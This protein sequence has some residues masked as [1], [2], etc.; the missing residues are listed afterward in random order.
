MWGD[1]SFIIIFSPNLKPNAWSSAARFPGG[2][3]KAEVHALPFDQVLSLGRS[4]IDWPR[5]CMGS[6]S[7]HQS[8]LCSWDPPNCWMSLDLSFPSPLIPSVSILPFSSTSFQLSAFC[9][10]IPWVVCNPFLEK[11]S[12]LPQLGKPLLWVTWSFSSTQTAPSRPV[13]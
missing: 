5:A 7:L 12:K 10:I 11:Q 4:P 6:I 13:F 1:S 3:A 2:W 9:Q 8:Q